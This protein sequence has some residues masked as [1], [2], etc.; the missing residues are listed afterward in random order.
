MTVFKLTPITRLSMSFDREL[1]LDKG[2]Q[3]TEKLYEKYLVTMKQSEQQRDG[4]L[5]FVFIV[6][7]VI[8]VLLTGKNIVVPWMGASTSD[9]PAVLEIATVL[10]SISFFFASMFF[11]NAVCYEQVIN[12]FKIR[13]ARTSAIDPDFLSAGDKLFHFPIKIFR[14]KMNIWGVDFFL[15]GLGFI[16]FSYWIMAVTLTIFVGL[17]VA[18][19]ALVAYSLWATLNKSGPALIQYVYVVGCALVNLGGLSL[20]LFSNK[21]YDFEPIKPVENRIPNV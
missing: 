21:A 20:F 7:A 19:F 5:K 16:A 15:P 18:H 17:L 8:A 3:F 6:D 12:Q 1:E 4:S 11:L 9:L 10:S 13:A 14:R 2:A